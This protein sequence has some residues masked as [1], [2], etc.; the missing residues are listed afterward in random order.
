MHEKMNEHELVDVWILFN[1]DKNR[2]PWR[3]KKPVI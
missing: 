1:P 3:G 2:Y